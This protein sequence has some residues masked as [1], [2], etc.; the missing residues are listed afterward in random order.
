[1]QAQRNERKSETERHVQRRRPQTCFSP[2][3]LQQPHGTANI[4]PGCGRADVA[5]QT[6]RE[7]RDRQHEEEWHR[8]RHAKRQLS[9]HCDGEQN[10]EK[11]SRPHDAEDVP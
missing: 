9:A 3:R 7:E 1:M 5:Q 10:L 4:G 8:D 2:D 11:S 6:A